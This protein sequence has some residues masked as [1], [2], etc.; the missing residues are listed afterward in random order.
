MN[1]VVCVKE[2]PN[3]CLPVEV[4][5][6]R[7]TVKDEEWNYIVNPCDEV[8]VEE[9]VRIKEKFGGEVTV[10]TL[11][12]DRAEEVL[13]KCLAIGADKAI[14][15]CDDTG[16]TWDAYTTAVILSKTINRLSYDIVLCGFQSIDRG[17]GEVGNIIAELLGLS[18]VT[19]VANLEVS[20]D[21]NS[22]TVSRRLERGAREI[23]KCPLPA[24]FTTD[25]ML[26]EPRYPTLPGIK[27]SLKMDIAKL[28]VKSLGA[29]IEG[30]LTRVVTISRPPPKKVFIPGGDLSPAQRIALLTGG[31]AAKKS[32]SNLLE[33]SA[34][35]VAKKAA[36]F[37]SERRFLP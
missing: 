19:A 32:S 29:E 15:I 26:N 24:V 37:L 9:A 35:E 4:D 7:N 25:L 23:K 27:K 12:S 30:P 20:A 6:Q 17:G 8:A 3:P 22:A 28:D 36:D 21:G 34:D 11:G 31:G 2:V 16:S 33:G 14:H 10:I 5:V 1:V 13:R 18:V